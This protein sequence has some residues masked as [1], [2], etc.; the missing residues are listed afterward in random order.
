MPNEQRLDVLGFE[1]LTKLL[2]ITS[3]SFHSLPVKST[4][5]RSVSGLLFV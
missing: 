5:E 3:S 2:Q 4:R 1:L